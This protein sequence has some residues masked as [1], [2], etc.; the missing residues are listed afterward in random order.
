MLASWALPPWQ[1]SQQ[2]E[3][4]QEH[5]EQHAFSVVWH[6]L[7]DAWMA[8]DAAISSPRCLKSHA[9]QIQDPTVLMGKVASG[10]HLLKA[11]I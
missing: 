6:S 8:A 10:F 3:H 9:E 1:T 4:L 11:R 7:N 5:H 2:P